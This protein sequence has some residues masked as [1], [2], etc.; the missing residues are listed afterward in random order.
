[1]VD[2]SSGVTLLYGTAESV[3]SDWAKVTP[4]NEG[5]APHKMMT[6]TVITRHFPVF[7]SI[8]SVIKSIFSQNTVN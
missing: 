4:G 7:M 5:T 3:C 1:M 8:A 2:S 6:A